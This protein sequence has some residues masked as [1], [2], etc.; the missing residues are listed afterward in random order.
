MPLDSVSILDGNTFVVSDRHGDLEASPTVNHG[1]FVNDTRFLSQW[2]LTVNGI[3]PKLLSVD[4]LSFNEARFFGALATGTIY[5][6]SHLSIVRRR[7]INNGFIEELTLM[8]HDSKPVDL[9]VRL[10]AAADFADL[11]EVKDMLPK[12]GTLSRHAE[13]ERLLFRYERESFVRQTAVSATVPAETTE[14]GLRFQVHLDSQA[15]WSVC[16]DV[17]PVFVRALRGDPA[18]PAHKNGGASA[19]RGDDVASW[20]AQ[21]PKLVSSSE[22]LGMTYR[23]SLMDLA[24]LRFRTPVTS[25]ALPAAGLPWFMTI[26]GRDSLI[27]SFEALP[28]FPEMA[29]ATLKTLALLQGQ[30]DDPFRDEEPGKIL[31]ELRFGELTAFEE[32]PHSP[33]FGGADSTPLFLV[34]LEEYVRWTGDVELATDLLPNVRAGL[35]WID[36]FGDRDKDGYVEYERRN[37]ET[38]LDN[39]CWKDSW[40]SIV[41]RDGTLAPTPRATC[42]I[43]GYVYDAKRRI[44]RLARDLYQDASWA[45]RLEAEAAALKDRFNRD[46]WVADRGF[47]AL[48]LDGHKRRVD[49]L[50]SNIG[51]LLW[52]GIADPDKTEQCVA[53]LMGSALFSGWGIRTMASTEGAYNPIGYHVGTVW[54]HDTAIVAWGLRQSGCRAEAARLALGILEATELFGHRPPEAFAGYPRAVTRFPVEYPTA[55]SPQAWATGA[56]LLMLRTLLGLDSDGRHLIVDPALPA[57]IRRLELLDIPGAWGTMDAF[58]RAREHTPTPAAGAAEA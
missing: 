3:R 57:Q 34:L 10:Q 36:E 37:T 39:Q 8:N 13:K 49:S 9:E 6:D 16:L 56:P 25:E 19:G 22:P 28:F 55:C 51:H 5:V 12:K 48:A 44:A 15:E 50:T 23:R 47:F 40:N 43:Q 31:H 45:A 7:T 26:F 17:E 29:R 27:T 46:F 4:D 35:A 24:A 18:R 42:E 52:S 30:K 11:F 14:D 38:G 21:A 1:L 58:G 33:Y 2:V 32:R 53:H 20:I 54:P 41:F